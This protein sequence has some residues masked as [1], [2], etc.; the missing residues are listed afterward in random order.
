LKDLDMN[1]QRLVAALAAASLLVGSGGAF[2]QPDRHDSR[3]DARYESQRDRADPRSPSYRGDDR[4]DRRVDDRR[5]GGN[6]HRGDDRRYGGNDRRGERGAGPDHSFYRGG[7]LPAQYRSRQ[8]VVS[9]WRGHRLS[10]PPR[11][12]QWVQTG[13]DFVLVAVATGIIASILL[14]Q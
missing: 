10:A 6:D 1:T 7:H 4:N 2:A 9:D 12:Y 14:N 11:G 13:S 8:Y 5:Y 3:G